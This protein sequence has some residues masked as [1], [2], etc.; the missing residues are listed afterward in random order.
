MKTRPDALLLSSTRLRDDS[1][2]LKLPRMHGRDS[3]DQASSHGGVSTFLS[4]E[5]LKNA[6][7]IQLPICNDNIQYTILKKAGEPTLVI[8]VVYARPGKILEILRDLEAGIEWMRSKLKR[9]EFVVL[10]DFNVHLG[11][12]SGDKTSDSAEQ[13]ARFMNYLK[14]MGLTLLRS[15]KNRQYTFRNEHGGRSIIDYALVSH[16]EKVIRDD[17]GSLLTV[18]GDITWGSDH[19][20]ISIKYRCSNSDPTQDWGE[21]VSERIKNWDNIEK[22]YK[23]QVAKNSDILRCQTQLRVLELELALGE[24]TAMAAKQK[25]K[26]LVSN[27]NSNGPTDK[28]DTTRSPT[29]TQKEK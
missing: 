4:Q 11:R 3:I 21:A 27:Y 5:L 29:E 17:D 8:I 20:A 22:E 24:I 15:E 7:E 9:P 14:K 12:L 28:M 6:E 16:P 26:G 13:V 10:G 2:Q 23:A 1:H 19:C 25:L 18:H